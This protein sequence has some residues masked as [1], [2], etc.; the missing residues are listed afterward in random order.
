MPAMMTGP[1][2]RGIIGLSLLCAS[3]T[4]LPPAVSDLM[5]AGIRRMMAK[6]EIAEMTAP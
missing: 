3:G 2:G 4:S 6:N 1:A 5:A